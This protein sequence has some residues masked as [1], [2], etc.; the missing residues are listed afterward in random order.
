MTASDTQWLI[1]VEDLL[2]GD[3][4]EIHF[5]GGPAEVKWQHVSK[6]SGSGSSGGGGGG[7]CMRRSDL[8]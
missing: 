8:K 2:A 4:E 3:G 5:M 1:E 7:V 6:G